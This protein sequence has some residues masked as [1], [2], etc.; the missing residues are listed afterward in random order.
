[1]RRVPHRGS[2]ERD[3]GGVRTTAT[4]LLANAVRR[5]ANG[6][7]RLAGLHAGA[8][9]GHALGDRPRAH[10]ARGGATHAG[11]REG[12]GE[13]GHVVLS[14]RGRHAVVRPKK[15]RRVRLFPTSRQRDGWYRRVRK[16]SRAGGGRHDYPRKPFPG[17]TDPGDEAENSRMTVAVPSIGRFQFQGFT[18]PHSEKASRPRFRG[19]RLARTS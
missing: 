17:R 11:G 8:S 19:H 1:M 16:W 14:G 12:G 9:G 6:D 10:G 7:V 13:G 15:W 5:R 2:S 3:V 4:G 18:N